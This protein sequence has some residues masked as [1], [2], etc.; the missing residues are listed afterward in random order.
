MGAMTPLLLMTAP[1][2]PR[3]LVLAVNGYW[4]YS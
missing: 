1:P 3:T 2:I 4:G